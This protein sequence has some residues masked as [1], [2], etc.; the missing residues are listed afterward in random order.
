M[1]IGEGGAEGILYPVFLKVIKGHYSFFVSLLTLKN[2][3]SG[4]SRT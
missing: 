1:L 2:D 4:L 3:K